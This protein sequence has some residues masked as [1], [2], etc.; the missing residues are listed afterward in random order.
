MAQV[1]QVRCVLNLIFNYFL[2][3]IRL[4]DTMIAKDDKT[5]LVMMLKTLYLKI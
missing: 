2:K 4:K 5:L 1:I 3:K